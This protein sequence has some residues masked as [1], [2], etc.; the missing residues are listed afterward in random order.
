MAS[1][2]VSGKTTSITLTN[3]IKSVLID[4]VPVLHFLNEVQHQLNIIRLCIRVALPLILDAVRV[5]DQHIWVDV[6]IGE[7]RKLFLFFS[8]LAT[9][10][11]REDETMGI[12]RCIHS[13]QVEKGFPA[14]C[15]LGESVCVGGKETE[16]AEEYGGESSP[17]RHLDYRTDSNLDK[18]SQSLSFSMPTSA[19]IGNGIDFCCSGN[20]AFVSSEQR[21]PFVPPTTY[22]NQQWSTDPTQSVYCERDGFGSSRKRIPYIWW[23][24]YILCLCIPTMNPT[25]AVESVIAMF[26]ISSKVSLPTPPRSSISRS[27]TSSEASRSRRC[28]DGTDSCAPSVARELPI[29]WEHW[30]AGGLVK[31]NGR[32]VGLSSS[33]LY[34]IEARSSS[35]GRSAISCSRRQTASLPEM[36]ASL[37]PLGQ[38]LPSTLEH[39]IQQLIEPIFNHLPKDIT[40]ECKVEIIVWPIL[41]IF[42]ARKDLVASIQIDLWHFLGLKV[43]PQTVTD[44]GEVGL[45]KL[46]L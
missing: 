7:L 31:A 8:V 18:A 25:S 12:S 40:V 45:Q 22:E 41:W 37:P 43:A 21:T 24:L 11:E 5:N 46:P 13:R 28:L 15:T 23:L 38:L 19:K 1:Q 3:S 14:S 30:I 20:Q 27:A 17:G 16:R 36:R 35:S 4:T 26:S 42:M 44:G 6:V 33:V 29:L 39:T 10:M 9:A 2:H 32:V 34:P